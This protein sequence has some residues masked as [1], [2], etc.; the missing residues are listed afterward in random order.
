MWY[1]LFSSK[2]I[3]P[4]NAYIA[5]T[6]KDIYHIYVENCDNVEWHELNSKVIEDFFKENDIFFYYAVCVDEQNP[7]SVTLAFS[8][9]K[10]LIEDDAKCMSG[11][12]VKFFAS[13]S[14]LIDFV[15]KKLDV[16]CYRWQFVYGHSPLTM[17]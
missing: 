7:L 14:G 2:I 5:E 11:G 6:G 17:L 15:H 12:S 10:P 8:N 13:F 1:D 3:Y 16:T 4:G 9:C